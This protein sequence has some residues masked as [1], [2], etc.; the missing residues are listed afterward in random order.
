MSTNI[1]FPL[2]QGDSGGPLTYKKG[3]QH[4]LIGDVSFGVKG[5]ATVNHFLFNYV[6][7]I[8][9]FQPNEPTAY[10]RISEV[11]GWIDSTIKGA[12]FCPHGENAEKGNTIKALQQCVLLTSESQGLVHIPRSQIKKGKGDFGLWTDF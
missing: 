8:F 7:F 5:C 11:R 12:K 4:I 3:D 6:C 9:Y 2:Y 10:C 1:Y